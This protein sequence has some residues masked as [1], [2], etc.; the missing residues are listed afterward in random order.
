MNDL[1]WIGLKAVPGIG[2]VT[3]RRLLERF[4]TPE[5]VLS[6][7]SPALAA[8]KSVTPGVQEAIAHGAWRDFAKQECYRLTASGAR[9]VTFTS[10]D[11][12]KSLFEIPDPPPFLYV[13]GELHSHETAVAIVGS[14]RATS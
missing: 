1:Y 13:Y 9:L 12:P 4:D 6:A 10:A 3:F 8:V 5:T 2:N 7:P 14:R 11:Y